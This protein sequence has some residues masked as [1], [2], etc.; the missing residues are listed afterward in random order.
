MMEN[1][2]PPKA[3]H[4][5]GQ[6]LRLKDNLFFPFFEL[7][8]GTLR[9]LFITI[10]YLQVPPVGASPPAFQHHILST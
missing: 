10:H 6:L 2:L 7:K 8:L 4:S 5:I 1:S 9:L 3:G